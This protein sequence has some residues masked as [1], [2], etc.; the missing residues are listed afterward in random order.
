MSFTLYREKE[1]AEHK[2]G[3]EEGKSKEEVNQTKSKSTAM[4][5]RV[6]GND[7]DDDDN[8]D[9]IDDLYNLAHY[10]SD[11]DLEGNT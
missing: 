9:D 11:E 3:N 6:G 5:S 8:D 10:D 2:A 7:S 1:E 4:K